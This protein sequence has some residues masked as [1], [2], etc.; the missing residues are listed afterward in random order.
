MQY[1]ETWESLQRANAEMGKVLFKVNSERLDLVSRANALESAREAA[2]VRIRD[3]EGAA[4]LAQERILD[5]EERARV[6]EESSRGAEERA[7]VAEERARVAEGLALASDKR[8][9]AAEEVVAKLEERVRA[10]EASAREEGL[11]HA[12]A[13]RRLSADA[14]RAKGE[15]KKMERDHARLSKSGEKTIMDLSAQV[16]DLQEQLDDAMAKL[17]IKH[18]EAETILFKYAVE[19]EFAR[20]TMELAA[21]T[22]EYVC[23]VG[24]LLH[25]HAQKLLGPVLTAGGPLDALI[26]TDKE[27]S[28]GLREWRDG[29]RKQ[30]KEYVVQSSD[31]GAAQCLRFFSKVAGP[32]YQVMLMDKMSIFPLLDAIKVDVA[33]LPKGAVREAVIRRVTFAESILLRLRSDV[34][35]AIPHPLVVKLREHLNG[36]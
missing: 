31:M 28:A 7:R 8:R 26:S 32:L 34:E 10:S 36:N 25:T 29:V 20:K 14:A 9:V 16:R 35:E 12:A 27:A 18:T 24:S 6:A 13:A 4:R 33:T 17:L 21:R 2:E 11:A 3:A 5:A 22:D 15:I 19:K 30:Y 23:D 1:E